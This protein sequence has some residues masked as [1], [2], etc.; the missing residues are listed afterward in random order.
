MTDPNYVN[1]YKEPYVLK[2]IEGTNGNYYIS[3]TGHVWSN[4]SHKFLKEWIRKD[5]YHSVKFKRE[6]YDKSIDHLIHRL[7][8]EA[9]LEN[10][11]NKIQ[12][13]HINGNKGKNNVS[14]LEWVT[15]E[16]NIQHA[17][18]L[19]LKTQKQLEDARPKALKSSSRTTKI[20]KD[21]KTYKFPTRKAAAN[22]LG[23]TDKVMMRVVKEKDYP[24]GVT[25]IKVNPI[26]K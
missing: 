2:E 12:V 8:A 14:N 24:E 17:I 15:Q 19:G 1:Y 13:N 25:K 3:D 26:G 20:I 16:E 18:R 23:I 7:V 4:Y 10:P 9:F 21:G 6:P 11:E 5:G 22:F